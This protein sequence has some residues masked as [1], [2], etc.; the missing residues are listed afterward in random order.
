MDIP[1]NGTWSRL[2]IFLSGYFKN[3]KY[4]I[5]QHYKYSVGTRFDIDDV[6]ATDKGGLFIIAYR[7]K[8]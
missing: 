3:Y 4:A 7:I 2:R 5:R 8:G 1:C 6:T